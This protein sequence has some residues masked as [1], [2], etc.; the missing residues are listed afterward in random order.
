M[1]KDSRADGQA[2]LT[3]YRATAEALEAIRL[4][5]L[6]AMTEEEALRR[7]KSLNVAEEPWRERPNWSG[8]VEQQALFHGRKAI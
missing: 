3:Q 5:E 1:S 6:A 2:W 7:I 4:Q 8:L